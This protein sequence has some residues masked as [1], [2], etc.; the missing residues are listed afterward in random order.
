MKEPAK[1]LS[2]SIRELLDE[3]VYACDYYHSWEYEE[4]KNKTISLVRKIEKRIGKKLWRRIFK[5]YLNLEMLQGENIAQIQE[6][7]YRLGFNDA[8]QLVN[9]LH[10]AGKGQ[11]NIFL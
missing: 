10:E 2:E 5:D 8:L 7:C 9:Q 6:S 11:L 3:R 4:N 1:P